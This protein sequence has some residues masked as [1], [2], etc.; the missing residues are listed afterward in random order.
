V[1]LA[2]VTLA[3]V[4]LDY[5]LASTLLVQRRCGRK[6]GSLKSLRVRILVSVQ[7]AWFIF[8]TKDAKATQR[9]KEE[10]LGVLRASF[11]SFVVKNTST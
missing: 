6:L 2:P 1:Q 7:G 3:K 5:F 4:A 9:A 8:T 11:V 10:K